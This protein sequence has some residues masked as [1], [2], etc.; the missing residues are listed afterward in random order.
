[1]IRKFLARFVGGKHSDQWAYQAA[2]DEMRSGHIRQGL[3]IKATAHA[4]GDRVQVEALYLRY[5]AEQIS[6]ESNRKYMESGV[7]SAMKIA[8][9][10]AELVKNAGKPVARAALNWGKSFVSNTAIGVVIAV[11]VGVVMTAS[12]E[13]HANVSSLGFVGAAAVPAIIIALIIVMV[14][15][16]LMVFQ[17]FRRNN[18]L[19]FIIAAIPVFLFVSAQW[20]GQEALKYY[21]NAKPSQLT[22]KT[23]DEVL[24][25]FEKRYPKL[26]PDSKQF[27]QNVTD[28]VAARMKQYIH[29]GYTNMDALE[30]AVADFFM[31]VSSTAPVASTNTSNVNVSK[32][33]KGTSEVVRRHCSDQYWKVVNSIQ[34][35]P[36]GRYQELEANA[37]AAMQRCEA[38]R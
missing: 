37:R 38:G 11:F 10:N 35:L 1:M 24:R 2:A 23:Y 28:S 33:P 27:D 9:A 25:D 19:A 32:V 34:N 18:G 20:K 30:R 29:A 3:M 22:K 26:N 12:S 16:V 14:M 21:Q 7:S 13:K 17:F 15:A 6:S 5:L 36:I 8:G 31:P 4:G